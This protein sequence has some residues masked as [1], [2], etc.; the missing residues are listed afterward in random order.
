MPDFERSHFTHTVRGMLS[1]VLDDA[2]RDL[3]PKVRGGK[4]TR[5]QV[6]QQIMQS[7]LLGERNSSRLKADAMKA[8]EGYGGL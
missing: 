7:A 8:L 1:R 5:E 4:L 3:D 2:W 6:A